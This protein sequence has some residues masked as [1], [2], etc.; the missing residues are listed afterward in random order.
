MKT[1]N[2]IILCII[3]ISCLLLFYHFLDPAH[4]L[5]APK[6][7]FKLLTGYQCPG[8]GSQRAIHSFLNGRILEGI[9]YNY[10][11]PPSL[12]YILALL[13]SPK[14]SRLYQA[15]TS[16]VAC[17]ILFAVIILWWIGRNVIGV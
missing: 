2:K 9:Q 15:L 10:L 5:L 11:L 6:C 12:L 14:G 16:S 13:I 8:C 3:G 4:C 1:K 17:W 7:P